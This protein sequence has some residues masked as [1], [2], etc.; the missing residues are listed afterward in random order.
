MEHILNWIKIIFT[1]V[2]GYLGVFLGGW[3]GFLYA[4]LVF[5]IIDYVT[6]V[7]VAIIQKKLSSEIGFVGICKKVLIF[8]LVAVGY[9]IDS[10]I[11]GQGGVIRTAIIFFYISNEGISIIEN[12]GL[13]GLPIPQ[14]LKDVLEQIKDQGGTDKNGDH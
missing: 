1:A 8:L 5:V 4:L 6:G 10:K 14:K 2:G 3:D 9:I 12:A 7:M 11:I 13:I